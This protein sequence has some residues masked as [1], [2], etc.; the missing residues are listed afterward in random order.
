MAVNDLTNSAG[1][2]RHFLV[3]YGEESGTNRTAFGYLAEVYA[4]A[5]ASLDRGPRAVLRATIDTVCTH[6]PAPQSGSL[7]KQDLL[8][9]HAPSFMAVR[10]DELDVLE[11]ILEH[12]ECIDRKGLGLKAR[13]QELGKTDAKSAWRLAQTAVKRK[14]AA[15]SDL[16]SGIAAGIGANDLCERVDSDWDTAVALINRT[17]RLGSARCLWAK[18]D[19]PSGE[20]FNALWA[21]GEPSEEQL[22][23]LVASICAEG[24][25]DAL[26]MVSHRAPASVAIAIRWL[27]HGKGTGR[28]QE[29]VE[30]LGRSSREVIVA[31][32]ACSPL[33]PATLK[34]LLG[35]I[36]FSAD[37]LKR[38]DASDWLPLVD[39]IRPDDDLIAARLFAL[40]SLA[41][42]TGQRELLSK[43][44]VLLHQRLAEDR[45]SPDAWQELERQL[46]TAHWWD[47]WDKCDRLR[48][49]FTALFPNSQGELRWFEFAA[50]QVGQRKEMFRLL[51]KAAGRDVAQRLRGHGS[52]K[53]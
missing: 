35:G 19:I 14:A 27:D 3:K 30:G 44:F 48:R 6:F 45:M 47:D 49:S 13:A 15:A 31:I 33:R 26:A 24:R 16:L 9:A 32:H 41:D 22:K 7:L 4:Q 28:G 38:S 29:V 11:E 37:D 1:T 18:A 23:T 21:R 52:E 20:I 40:S 12:A 34:Q 5:A 53:P 42:G 50:N 36:G 10:L 43:S 51:E 39:S 46:P 25:S 2:F 17:P 8:G